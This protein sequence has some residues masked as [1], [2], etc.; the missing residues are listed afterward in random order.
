MKK[1]IFLHIVITLSILV[2]AQFPSGINYQ[3]VVRNASGEI[4]ADT[5]LS[6]QIIIRSN[7]PDGQAVYTEIHEVATNEYGLINIVIGQGSILSGNF[8][9]INWSIAPYFFETA[10]TLNG[11]KEF[12]TLGVT[13]FLSVPYALHAKT[14]TI[15]QSGGQTVIQNDSL[16]LKDSL[17]VT[18]MILNPNTGS[19]RM[20]NNDTVWYEVQVQSPPSIAVHATGGWHI[21]YFTNKHGSVQHLFDPEGN[22]WHHFSE[23]LVFEMEG[24]HTYYENFQYDMNPNTHETYICSKHVEDEVDYK[25]SSGKNYRETT[26]TDTKLDMNEK[27]LSRTVKNEK[28]YKSGVDKGKKESITTTYT[29]DESGNEIASHIEKKEFEPDATTV[30]STENYKNNVLRT[31]EITTVSGTSQTRTTANKAFNGTGTLTGEVKQTINP[32]G[33]QITEVTCGANSTRIS[34]SAHNVLLNSG[35]AGAP[36]IEY[37]HD[38]YLQE[39]AI[40]SVFGDGSKSQLIKIDNN[41]SIFY[42][43][44]NN[45]GLNNNSIT[46]FTPASLQQNVTFGGNTSHTGPAYFSGGLYGTQAQLTG[47]LQVGTSQPA[48]ITCTGSAVIGGN[49]DITGNASVHGSLEVDGDLSVG[50]NMDF[51]TANLTVGSLVSNNDLAAG[52]IK[53]FVIEHPEN[54]SQLIQHAA[55]ESN[56]VYNMYFGNVVT[57]GSGIAEVFLPEYFQ[58]I[59]NNEDINYQITVKN[60][61]GTFVQAIVLYEYDYNTNSF[62]VKTSAPNTEVHWQVTAKRADSYMVIYPFHDV[63]EK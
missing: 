62:F 44:G 45:I 6:L 32:V 13:Q 18:R 21:K 36:G 2:H 49:S 30:T 52:G 8:G 4:L 53:K 26:I 63:I 57:N 29:Y 3:T 19:I 7:A 33:E 27:I 61:M 46:L 34:Q 11:G 42:G 41:G 22:L 40:N 56:Q 17:G 43:P 60:N 9:N 58:Y 15:A 5:E 55:V 28:Y 51:G 1:L 16:V 38:D 12:Q 54:S 35:L 37:T 31:Q 20:M 50:G 24:K 47:G 14:A 48:N 39:T 10:I 25:E 59:N 23:E